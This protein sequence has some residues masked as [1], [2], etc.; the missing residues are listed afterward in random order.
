MCV[1][2]CAA[3][4]LYAVQVVAAGEEILYTYDVYWQET[5]VEWERRWDWYRGGSWCASWSLLWS[6]GLLGCVCCAMAACVR[7]MSTPHASVA[8]AAPA[9]AKVWLL[10]DGGIAS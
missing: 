7:R 2:V 8:A 3:H 4:A 9:G 6:L 1:C 10:R 5:D